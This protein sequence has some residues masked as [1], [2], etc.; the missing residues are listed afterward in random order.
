MGTPMSNQ[1]KILKNKKI[2]VESGLY[3]CND[4]ESLYFEILDTVLEESTEKRALLK[5]W[6]AAKDFKGY[7]REVHALKNVAAT[8][9][10]DHFCDYLNNI[11][12]T[13]KASKTFP[14]PLKI[15]VL[16]KRYDELLKIIKKSKK[17]N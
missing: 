3:Y 2:D 12:A 1:L 17:F 8:I 16:I 13:M 7:Y 9:G 11:C 10:A 6:A 4:N 14:N 5:K 15:W